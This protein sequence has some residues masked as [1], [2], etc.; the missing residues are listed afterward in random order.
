MDKTFGF[1]KKQKA[2]TLVPTTVV[3]DESLSPGDL[4]KI[5][6]EGNNF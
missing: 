4:V 6:N 1:P 2:P 3:P 5:V